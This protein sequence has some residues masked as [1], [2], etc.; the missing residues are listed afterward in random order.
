MKIIV[1]RHGE[2]EMLAPSDKERH[3]THFGKTSSFQQSQWLKT[4]LNSTALDKVI[5]SPYLRAL[6]TFEQTNAAFGQ[7]LTDCAETWDAVTPYGSTNL[8]RN[9]L[10]TIVDDQENANV[11]LISHLPLVG[12]IVAEFCGRNTVSFRP[13]TIACIDW[14]GETGKIIEIKSP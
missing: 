13:A 6:E 10:E 11:L 1:M 14:D 9:Y 7:R 4:W 8:I 12:E 3:L 5:V 2:A